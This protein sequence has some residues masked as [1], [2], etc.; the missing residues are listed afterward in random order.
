[1]FSCFTCNLIIS[2]PIL[3]YL[4]SLSMSDATQMARIIL[5]QPPLFI[6]FNH[7]PTRFLL[8]TPKITSSSIGGLLFDSTFFQN[9]GF[10]CIRQ[11]LVSH[12]TSLVKDILMN[13]CKSHSFTCQQISVKAYFHRLQPACNR[14]WFSVVKR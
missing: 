5:P 1:M 10:N 14:S 2:F 6:Y 12:S 4:V 3:I 13:L 8:T 9:F 7:S 11:T